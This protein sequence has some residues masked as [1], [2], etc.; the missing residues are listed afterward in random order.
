MNLKIANNENKRGTQSQGGE[1]RPN[2]SAIPIKNR[3]NEEE[4][5]EAKESLKLLKMKIGGDFSLCNNKLGGLTHY[6][7]FGNKQRFEDRANRTDFNYNNGQQN[8]GNYRKPFQ[9]NFEEPVKEFN[10]VK[11]IRETKQQKTPQV[12]NKTQQNYTNNAQNSQN[13]KRNDKKEEKM[14]AFEKPN[15]EIEEL[16]DDRPAKAGANKDDYEEEEE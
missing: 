5:K 12:L 9:P 16:E 4:I 3:F 6:N 7:N 13:G 8:S 10:E 14:V 2:K 11:D 1:I 15:F